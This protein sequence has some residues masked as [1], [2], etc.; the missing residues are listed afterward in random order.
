MPKKKTVSQCINSDDCK[1][2]NDAA[3]AVG[4]PGVGWIP[5]KYHESCLQL[6]IRRRIAAE[7]TARQCI[8]NYRPITHGRWILLEP[9]IGLA[10]CSECEH[11]IIRAKCNYCPNC[12]AKMDGEV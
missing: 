12:G 2:W 3:E 8:E 10:G 7:H 6:E 11:K 4:Y 1:G 5:M 9:E